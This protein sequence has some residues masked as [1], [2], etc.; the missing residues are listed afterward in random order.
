MTW[1]TIHLRITTPVFNGGHDPVHEDGTAIRVPSILGA[2]RFWFRALAGAHVG[3]DLAA[4]RYWEGRVFGH[5]SSGDGA[6]RDDAASAIQWR[7]PSQPRIV[8]PGSAPDWLP[9]H[10]KTGG[11]QRS[12]KWIV[13]LLGQGL[14]NLKDCTLT[15]PYVPAG[16]DFDLKFRLRRD[17]PVALGLA[18]TA[19]WLT[20][21][22][23]GVGARTRRGFGGL[24]IDGI[25]WAGLQ[26]PPP[27]DALPFQAS[28]P[29]EYRRLTRLSPECVGRALPLFQQADL[30]RKDSPL[31]H[32]QTLPPYPVL[33]G[34]ASLSGQE[35]TLA[36]L[37]STAYHSWDLTLRDIGYRWRRFRASE[38]APG[39]NYEPKVK[40]PEWT[41]VIVGTEDDEFTLGVLGLPVG[42]KGKRVV[43]AV[44][45][46]A[47]LRRASPLWLRPVQI[48]DRWHL[49]SFAFLSEFLPTGGSPPVEVHLFE[50][51]TYVRTLTVPEDQVKPWTEAWLTEIKE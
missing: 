47:Q 44:A 5:A 19:L 18:L 6:E 50:D 25:D 9:S 21:A 24:K 2:M 11:A 40:T 35:T 20:C 37:G 1:S 16:Q 27:W 48:N 32:W 26:P 28:T 15:R 51:K 34:P 23:G 42:Y 14:G 31:H 45:D 22:Y 4:L 12:D 46:G 10:T 39:A 13:Y 36:G 3:P 29:D 33:G 38:D 30:H 17:D 7:I 41:A 43:N 8:A 49:F